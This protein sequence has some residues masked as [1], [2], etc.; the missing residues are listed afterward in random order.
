MGIESNTVVKI[1]YI[2]LCFSAIIGKLTWKSCYKMCGQTDEWTKEPIELAWRL[3]LFYQT[4]FSLEMERCGLYW[5][6]VFPLR[7]LEGS[8][9]KY[10]GP[11]KWDS[12]LLVCIIAIDLVWQFSIIPI[13]YCVCFLPLYRLWIALYLKGYVGQLRW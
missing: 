1:K 12:S 9:C 11:N 2:F 7:I 10:N 5:G 3:T 8:I 13:I 4:Q 6:T